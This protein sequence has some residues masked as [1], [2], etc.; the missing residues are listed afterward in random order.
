MLPDLCDTWGGQSDN[1]NKKS[2][3][4][5]REGKCRLSVNAG[6]GHLLKEIPGRTIKLKN[7]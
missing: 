4:R 6:C 5:R 1:Q 2:R 7:D 3:E